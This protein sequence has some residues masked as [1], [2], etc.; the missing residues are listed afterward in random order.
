MNLDSCLKKI[1]K[2]GK[3][4][5]GAMHIAFGIDE[6]FAA[7]MGIMMTSVI[8][9]NPTQYF[10]FHIF[11]DSLNCQ[12]EQKLMRIVDE[13]NIC[14]YIYY[15]DTVALEHKFKMTWRTV[16]NRFLVTKFLPENAE[17]ILYLDAD[18]ICLGDISRLKDIDFEG[19]VAMVVADQGSVEKYIDEL[20]LKNKQYFNAGMLYIDVYLWNKELI[21]ERALEMLCK[22]KLFLL[23]QDA[24]N[25]LL[26]GKAKFIS[27]CWNNMCNMEK[28]RSRIYPD[29]VIVHY[30][31]IVKPWY[32]W[33]FHPSRIP[34]L[35]Y[36]KNSFWQ[37]FKFR[38]QPRNYR[39]MRTMCAYQ[40]HIGEYSSSLKWFIRYLKQRKMEKSQH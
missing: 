5:D 11:V 16:Y 18:M 10:C 12:D 22:R 38:E 25:I 21:S 39:E 14:I 9:N 26:D 28:K 6:N 7:P 17:R 32:V 2:L 30:A 13:D 29:T 35:K 3:I 40:F 31:S 27:P 33:C 24:L 19:K 23:D 4:Q 8:D 15:I 34:W 20:N 1:S 37:D 36:Y